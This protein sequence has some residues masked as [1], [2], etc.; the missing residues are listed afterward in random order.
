MA[1]PMTSG[2]SEKESVA[3]GSMFASGGMAAM[4]L[5]T[6]LLTGSI[7]VLSEA[8]HSLL[9]LGATALTYFAV[10]V[11][12]KPADAEHPYGHAKIE[13][14]S[15][16]IETGLLFLTSAWIIKEAVER[17]LATGVKVEATWYAVMVIVVSIV[18]DYFRARA[19]MRVAKATQSQALEADALHFSTDIFSSSV[20]LLGL[21]GV[22]FGFQQADAVAALGVAIF[23]CRAGYA[24]G[25]RTL[26]ILIDTAPEGVAERVMALASRVAGIARVDRVRV[27]P[28]GRTIFIEIMA[29]VGRMLPLARVQQASRMVTESVR[30]EF[31]DADVVVHT[32]PLALDNETVAD[33][34]RLIAANQGLSTYRIAVQKVRQQL[35]VSFDLEVPGHHSIRQ[36]HDIASTLEAAVRHELGE[37][38][39]IDSHITP[40]LSDEM[41]EATLESPPEVVAAIQRES[42]GVPF[43]VDVHNIKIRRTTAGLYIT[44][45][46]R[47]EDETPLE[48]VENSV[49]RLERRLHDRIAAAR[50]IVVHAEPIWHQD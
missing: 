1:R 31:P 14:V 11:S 24:L 7:G 22:H 2:I 45:H 25:R 50:R 44:F 16:L 30:G 8:A 26:D 4:K 18:I 34:I 15:A 13:S 40:L 9:D 29:S 5:I 12:D 28:A 3:L 35:C 43:L 36:A 19:L 6:G 33:R 23:V 32:Q 10:R 42:G 20:V 17:L 38:V 27:R 37:D 39:I 48:Q 47:F 41:E 49:R 21:A 46:C